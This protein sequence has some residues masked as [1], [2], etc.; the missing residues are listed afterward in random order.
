[1]CALVSREGQKRARESLIRRHSTVGLR[2]ALAANAECRST[3]ALARVGIQC[4]NVPFCPVRDALNAVSR[5]A[6]GKSVSRSL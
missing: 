1:M 6:M 3:C 2:R 4:Y 5:S